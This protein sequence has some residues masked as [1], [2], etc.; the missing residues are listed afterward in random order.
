MYEK[1]LTDTAGGKLDMS[2]S[3]ADPHGG[4][5]S[6]N[7]FEITDGCIGAMYSV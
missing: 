6:G 2:C 1:G 7:L 5:I 3:C 4:E